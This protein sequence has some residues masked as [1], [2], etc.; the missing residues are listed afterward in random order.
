ML[1]TEAT[2]GTASYS[3]PEAAFRPNSDGLAPVPFCCVVVLST[4]IRL[5]KQWC[6]RD[7][8]FGAESSTS[9]SGVG[10]VL[11]WLAKRNALEATFASSSSSSLR[12]V[13]L[14]DRRT[15][16][17]T[18]TRLDNLEPMLHIRLVVVL[19]EALTPLP[20]DAT[21]YSVLV[22]EVSVDRN[23]A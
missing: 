11:M 4:S 6:G 21:K 5:A 8:A 18:S 12:P 20:T 9:L 22:A 1:S 2:R 17:V 19:K 16:Q 3:G 7:Q 23:V 13:N 10:V 14:A 15:T